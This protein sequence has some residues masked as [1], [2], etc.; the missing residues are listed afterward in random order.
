MRKALI[1]VA[2][3]TIFALQERE[4]AN[5]KLVELSEK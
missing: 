2:I 1:A 3:R 5:Q 4:A